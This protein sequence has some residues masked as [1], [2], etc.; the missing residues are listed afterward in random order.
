MPQLESPP[1]TGP[2]EVLTTQAKQI[3]FSK[4]VKI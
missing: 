4:S 1:S 2:S 3:K